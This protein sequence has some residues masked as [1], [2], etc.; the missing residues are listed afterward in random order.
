MVCNNY[1]QNRKG[2]PDIIL[3]NHITKGGGLKL[4]LESYKREYYATKFGDIKIEAYRRGV[5]SRGYFCCTLLS[6]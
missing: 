5:S 1:R 4:D 6:G 2:F 3:E